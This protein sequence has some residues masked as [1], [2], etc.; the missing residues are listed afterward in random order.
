[1][2]LLCIAEKSSVIIFENSDETSLDT[3]VFCLPQS[4]P[5][6]RNS[7]GS[8]HRVGEAMFTPFG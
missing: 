1:M 6:F 5:D 3:I 8:K 2:L 7:T 4:S